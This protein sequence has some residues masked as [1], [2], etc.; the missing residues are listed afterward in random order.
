[1]RRGSTWAWI[2][3]ILAGPPAIG[4]EVPAAFAPLEYLVGGW[5]GTGIPRANRLKGWNETHN[6]AWKFDKG[7]PVAMT[8]SL[9]GD[10]VIKK[11]TLTYDAASKSYRLAGTD[12]TDK[13]VVFTGTLDTSGKVLT[14]VR[15]GARDKV[16]ERITLRPNSSKIRYTMAVDRQGPGAPQFSKF[17]EVGVTKEGEAFASGG[18]AAN[19]P[20]C[21]ITGGSATMVVSFGG[22][23]YP[24]CC[25]GCR[26]EFEADPEK[27][28]AKAKL[29]TK[30]ADK[31]KPAPKSDDSAFDGLVDDP[32]AKPKKP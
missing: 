3:L 12:P 27:Y 24:I 32:P 15:E 4:D 19:L 16:K 11:A 10:K 22:Q 1:M 7:T 26:D 25:T 31:P 30:T 13:P 2:G 28:V 17:I 20:K 5:K 23:S 6:W 14:L 29:Q 18:A 9:E 8:V 21:I